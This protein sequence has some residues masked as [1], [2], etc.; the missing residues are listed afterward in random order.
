MTGN[1]TY[2]I[3]TAADIPAPFALLRGMHA[4]GGFLPLDEGKALARAESLVDGGFVMVARQ[5]DEMIGSVA[6][7][8]SDL[9]YSSQPVLRD[10]WTYVAPGHRRSLAAARLL[11]AARTFARDSEMPMFMAV[12][13]D[14]ETERKERLFARFLRPV[15][16]IFME[17]P[18][19][20][21]RG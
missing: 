2:A 3:P 5:G 1:V 8:R 16:R 4:E 20:V 19:H 14:I 9:W 12:T 18:G 6:V 10:F 21:L 7:G 11:K 15:G 13:S 17:D